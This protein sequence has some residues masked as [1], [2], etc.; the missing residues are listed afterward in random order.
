MEEGMAN[1]IREVDAGI[2]DHGIAIPHIA[3]ISSAAHQR[4]NIYRESAPIRP[5]QFPQ[6]S[7]F[8]QDYV[9]QWLPHYGKNP[10]VTGL[11]ALPKLIDLRLLVEVCQHLVEALQGE[12]VRWQSFVIEGESEFGRWS[13]DQ[14]KGNVARHRGGRIGKHMVAIEGAQGHGGGSAERQ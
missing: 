2:Y 12:G 4:L 1:L 8:E 14:R 9:A 5:E 6:V 11:E 13:D 7:G 10:V 3:D